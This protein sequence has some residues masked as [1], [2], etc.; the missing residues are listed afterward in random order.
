M[1]CTAL[2]T[3]PRGRPSSNARLADRTRARDARRE[4][5]PNAS[6]RE[7]ERLARISRAA[8]AVSRRNRR[9]KFEIAAPCRS[10]ARRS[11]RA[12]APSATARARV[13]AT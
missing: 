7:R 13:D 8:D 1:K 5:A 6:A 4:R 9:A 3:H 12:R 11:S 10:R 2:F